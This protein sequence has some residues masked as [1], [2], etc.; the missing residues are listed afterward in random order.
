MKYSDFKKL[1]EA[2]VNNFPMFFAFDNS[3][4]ERGKEK[5]GVKDNSELLSIGAGGFIRKA[6]RQDFQSVLGSD[7]KALKTF[8]KEPDQFLDALIYELNNHE[9]CVTCDPTDALEALNLD[10]SKFTKKQAELF[11]QAKA[12]SMACYVY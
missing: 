5:L 8:L 12:T 11:T 7:K 6:D 4:F 10:E 2:G 1:R 3:A 9:Y